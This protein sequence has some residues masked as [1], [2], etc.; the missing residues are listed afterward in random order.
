MDKLYA[1]RVARCH[2]YVEEMVSHIAE[3]IA[4]R[5]EDPI[6]RSVARLI[7]V[8]SRKHSMILSDIADLLGVEKFPTSDC[9][10]YSGAAYGFMGYLREMAE[11]ASRIGSDE[12]GLEI[13]ESV[14]DVLT[15]IA[16]ADRTLITEG[17]EGGVKKYFI[18]L[19]LSMD[20][21]D[22]RHITLLREYRDTRGTE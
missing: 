12:E 19:L 22:L 1:G 20:D 17:L 10:R 3:M 7:S 8:D 9:S 2:Q 18:T 5:A 15:S 16:M 6:L 14:T 13:L 11:K 4:E 21:D